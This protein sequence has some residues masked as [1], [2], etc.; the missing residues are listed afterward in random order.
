MTECDGAD[1]SCSGG[2]KRCKGL[3]HSKVRRDHQRKRSNGER[4][5]RGQ[6]SFLAQP[7]QPV[8]KMIVYIGGAT[9]R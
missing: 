6:P 9:Y 4:Q 3:T 8:S 2:V 1:V 7:T 5:E